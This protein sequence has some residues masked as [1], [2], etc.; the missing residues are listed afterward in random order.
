MTTRNAKN[1]QK[2]QLIKEKKN[3]FIYKVI[4]PLLSLLLYLSKL[5]NTTLNYIYCYK[6][7]CYKYYENK[8]QSTREAQ[9]F[10]KILEHSTIEN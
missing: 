3:R 5:K 4:V 7:Y 9:I 8:H 6:I 10:K 1:P 2:S